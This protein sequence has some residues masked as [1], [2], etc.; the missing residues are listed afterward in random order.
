[1]KDLR[2][3]FE[4]NATGV[5]MSTMMFQNGAHFG[6]EFNLKKMQVTLYLITFFF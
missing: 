3:K 4:K 1:M 2:F 5:T 6:F